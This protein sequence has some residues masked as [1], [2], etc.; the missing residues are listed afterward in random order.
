[1]DAKRAVEHI[2]DTF[3]IRHN[4]DL[5]SPENVGYVRWIHCHV[6]R[7]RYVFFMCPSPSSNHAFLANIICI[8]K[9]TDCIK[10]DTRY[11]TQ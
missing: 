2:L 9:K 5:D 10:Y 8:L 11:K 1:M 6:G 3:G 7:K 4:G